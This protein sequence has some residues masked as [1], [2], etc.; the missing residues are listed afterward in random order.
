MVLITAIGSREGY[1][2]VTPP[3]QCLKRNADSL[4]QRLADKAIDGRTCLLRHCCNATM[5]LRCKAYVEIAA[6]GLTWL[7]ASGLTT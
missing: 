5:Y 1:K 4:C 7:N 2:L 3:P 6:I